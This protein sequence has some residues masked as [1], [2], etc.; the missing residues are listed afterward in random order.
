MVRECMDKSPM[1][2]VGQSF[3]TKWGNIRLISVYT[4]G[5]GKIGI[6]PNGKSEIV[7]STVDWKVEDV[8]YMSVETNFYTLAGNGCN[9]WVC[10]PDEAAPPETCTHTFKLQDQSGSPLNG[11]VQIGT[12]AITVLGTGTITLEKGK[13]Y[14]AVASFSDQSTQSK[15]FTACTITTFV[16]NVVPDVGILNITSDPPGASISIQF[17]PYGVTPKLGIELDLGVHFVTLKLEGYR[18]VTKSVTLQAGITGIISE[19]LVPI[20]TR[21]CTQSFK[22]HD[23]LGNPLAGVISCPDWDI[24]LP[25]PNTGIANIRLEKGKTF[26]V[27][28]HSAGKTETKTFTSCEFNAIVFTIQLDP[29]MGF[30][31]CQAYDSVTNAAL[32]ATLRIDGTTIVPK[33]PHTTPAI[34]IGTHTVTFILEGYT[35]KNV[36]VYVQAG[37]T[38]NA[39]GSMVQLVS[40]GIV[41]SSVPSLASIY[42]DG[43]NTLQYTPHTLGGVSSGVHTVTYYKSGYEPTSRIVNV[44]TGQDVNAYAPMYSSTTNIVKMRVYIQSGVSGVTEDTFHDFIKKVSDFYKSKGI[45]VNFIVHELKWINTPEPSSINLSG[46]DL[47]LV[48][49]EGAG[50]F[51]GTIQR[52]GANLLNPFKFTQQGVV[53]LAHEFGHYFGVI[54]QYWLNLSNATTPLLSSDLKSSIMYYSYTLTNGFSSLEKEIIRKNLSKLLQGDKSS[55]LYPAERWSGTLKIYIGKT[56]EQCKIFSSTRN[57][58]TFNSS[59]PSTPTLTKSTDSAGVLTIDT[60]NVSN[61]VEFDLFKIECG[62]FKVWVNSTILDSNYIENGIID[63]C[64]ARYLNDTQWCVLADLPEPLGAGFDI[65][66]NIPG[67]LPNSSLFI[68]EVDKIPLTNTWW[69][70]PLGTGMRWDNISNGSFKARVSRSDCTPYPASHSQLR[71]GQDYVIFVGTSAISLYPSTLVKRLT[72]GTTSINI[73]SSYVDWVS[74]NLCAAMGI[75]PS[76]CSNF[77]ATTVS[78]AAF[79]LELWTIITKHENLAGEPT[80]PTALDIALIPIAIFGMFSPGI[81]EGK[82]TEIV[83]T[84]ITHLIQISREGNDELKMLLQDPAL[85]SFLMRATADQFM[86]LT[87]YLENGQLYVAK[88]LIKSLE[89]VPLTKNE[90]HALER[91]IKF[92]ETLDPK[93]TKAGSVESISKILAEFS[94]KFKEI[95]RNALKYV[96]DHPTETIVIGAAGL[97]MVG[98]LAVLNRMTGTLD[99]SF[100]ADGITMSSTSWGGKDY[101]DIIDTYR[102]NVQ[103]AERVSNW[104]LFCENLLLWEEQVDKFEAFVSANQAKLNVE[105]Y[106][107]IFIDTI[108]VYRKAIEIKHE[109]HSC[110]EQSVPEALNAKVTEILDGDTVRIDYNG[111]E[112]TVRL[113]GINAPEGN[114]Y[115]YSCTGIRSP[116]LIRRLVTPG[117][118]CIEEETWTGTVEMYNASKQWLGEHL[119]VNQISLFKSDPKMQFD[120]YGRFL[121]VPVHNDLNICKQSLRE[122]HSVVFFYD[123]NKQVFMPAYLGAETIAKDKKIGV[124][125]TVS[126]L[127][128][129]RCVSNPTASEV[130]L[131]GVYTGKKTSSSV[132]YLY[133]IPVGE[134]TVEFKKIIDGVKHACSKKITVSKGATT[135]VECTLTSGTTPTP[136]PTPKPGEAT[137]YIGYAKNASGTILNV[138]K[139]YVD[140]VYVGHYAPELLRFCTGCRCDDLVPCGFGSHTVTIKK[141]GYKDWFKTRTIKEGDEVTDNPVMEL[142]SSDTFPVSLISQ[143]SGATIKVDGKSI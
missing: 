125:A 28:A 72:S 97:V 46:V 18:S 5:S 98:L 2:G 53:A 107:G 20:P 83:G 13:S 11:N 4:S 78:D 3:V 116:Y 122:G 86:N 64:E 29:G 101:V 74:T 17:I 12:T 81:S 135:V 60:K 114:T 118:E 56:N 58:N 141:T 34:S 93:L 139:V 7:I 42:L 50:H 75:T 48:A 10:G 94:P 22:I 105:G 30:I 140:T 73:T 14:T 37:Q 109:V 138:A 103:D 15:T 127:G 91:A 108:A 70:S 32:N 76:N 102:Y 100:K 132:A 33:T 121:A 92:V 31:K 40:T 49:G 6:T 21:A 104:T 130:W 80:S 124:W 89:N 96:K 24:D 136:T 43:K 106:Y 54:D 84:R 26:I 41:C 68:F 61:R 57:Y 129:I 126:G 82:I 87:K 38:V 142:L 63:I 143:P 51:I 112:Y 55:I 71:A 65:N 45:D 62:G 39:Y 131:D 47:V 44:I 119:P 117:K 66:V 88:T 137:W 120:K 19:T 113:L 25:V 110:G 23:Q 27:T 77:I 67:L 134:H 1:I 90:I 35:P 79:L 85:N 115:D 9:F 52:V 16:F 111:K 8:G 69:D 133:N 36:S 128:T 99:S 95:F 59:F 123:T